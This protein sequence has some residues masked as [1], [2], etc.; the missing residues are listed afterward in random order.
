MGPTSDRNRNRMQGG[1]TRQRP[2]DQGEALMHDLE[3]KER[4]LNAVFIS[5]RDPLFVRLYVL[6]GV[7]DATPFLLAGWR[8]LRQ[9]CISHHV[10][11]SKYT[12]RTPAVPIR[13]D[14]LPLFTRDCVLDGYASSP[15]P[16][17]LTNSARLY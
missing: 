8:D 16:V 12:E 7:D 3:Q 2:K 9:H 4:S 17:S 13:R 6:F 1:S 11:H 5:V 10:Q 14:T 15:C